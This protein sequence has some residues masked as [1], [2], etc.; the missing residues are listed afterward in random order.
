VLDQFCPVSVDIGELDLAILNLGVNAR[1]AMPQGGT[2]T[3]RVHRVELHG[4]P[5]DLQGAFVALSV[6]DTGTG[7]KPA[8][9]P[10]VFEPF[11]T[12][13]GV[14]RGQGRGWGRVSGFARQRGGPAIVD[15]VEG[16]GPAVTL[17]LPVSTMEGTARAAAARSV[18]PR[19]FALHVLIVEDEKD[20]AI[21]A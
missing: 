7:I 9:L 1:D 17:Y 13:R 12:T 3:L 8:L 19:R 18:R 2:L 6:R 20:V 10:R 21:L 15:S 4:V 11:F 14:G 5:D 16:E